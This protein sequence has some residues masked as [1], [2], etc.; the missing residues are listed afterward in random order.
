MGVPQEDGT[1]TA[2]KTAKLCMKIFAGIGANVAEFD[3]D[4]APPCTSKK[5]AAE[6][7]HQPRAHTNLSFCKFTRR[8]ARDGVL[9]KRREIR[10]P[11]SR[12]LRPSYWY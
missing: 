5:I 9:A 7:R 6:D 3:I 2:E 12:D 11:Y 1:E 8:I 10:R 4:T